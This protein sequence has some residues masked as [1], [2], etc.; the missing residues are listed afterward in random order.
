MQ[1]PVSPDGH[2]VTSV[3]G[4]GMNDLSKVAIERSIINSCSLL[5]INVHRLGTKHIN[6]PELFPKISFFVHWP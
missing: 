2:S 6:K 4:R 3:P 1:P 5:A